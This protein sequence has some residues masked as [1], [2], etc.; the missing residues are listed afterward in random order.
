MS[1]MKLFKILKI[2]LII[3]GSSAL[4]L[5]VYFLPP[6]HSRLS[7]RLASLRADIYYL[8]NPPGAV[9]FSPGQQDIMEDL[10]SQTQTAIAQQPTATVEPTTAPTDL[11][12][13]TPTI[14]PTPYH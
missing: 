10:L 13:P 2:F 8:L 1:K 11:I 3:I 4:L 6:V 12:S 5:A 7:W 14:T 9:A